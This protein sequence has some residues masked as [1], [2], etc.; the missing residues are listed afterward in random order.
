M[1]DFRRSIILSIVVCFVILTLFLF[2]IFALPGVLDW[3][4]EAIKS[5]D[6]PQMLKTAV[7]SCFYASAPFAFITLL[8]LIKMLL[9]IN[10]EEIF[11]NANISRLRIISWCC[12]AVAAITLIGGW[13]YLPLAV[14]AVAAG[15]MGLILRVVKNVMYSAKKLREENDLT[16]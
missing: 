6:T 5:I 3:Y 7:I 2:A 11:I 12:F 15:F 10:R 14:I 16:I 8:C 1:W 13:F 4:F 9:A